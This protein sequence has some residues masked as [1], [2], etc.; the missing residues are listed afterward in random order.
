MKQRFFAP[1]NWV[2]FNH[3]RKSRID[4]ASVFKDY[5]GLQYCVDGALRLTIGSGAAHQLKGPVVWVTV[6]GVSYKYEG[7]W[8]HC[9]VCFRGALVRRYL[10]AEML[11]ADRPFVPLTNHYMFTALFDELLRGLSDEATAQDMNVHRFNALLFC[12]KDATR[13]QRPP[14][15]SVQSVMALAN[16]ID[17][18]PAK[19]WNPPELAKK[20]GM[21]YSHM[22]RTFMELYST[23]IGAYILERKIAHAALLLRRTDKSIKEIAMEGG[24]S[25]VYYFTKMFR[26]KRNIPPGT[27]RKLATLS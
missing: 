2:G 19:A 26:K 22:R 5:Y 6:P 9:F 20:T 27:Y 3:W 24:F 12:L 8:E 23:P 16:E 17:R 14:S 11:P 7:T 25:D 10:A 4:F 1:L 15:R 13:M 18:Y 21:S